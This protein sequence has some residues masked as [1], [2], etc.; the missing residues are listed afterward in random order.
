MLHEVKTKI[1]LEKFDNTKILTDT[2]DN[3]TDSVTLICDINHLSY[4]KWW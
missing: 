2:N 4:K 1:G 3:L